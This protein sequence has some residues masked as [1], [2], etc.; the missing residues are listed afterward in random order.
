MN[1]GSKLNKIQKQ[2]QTVEQ[3]KR[4][5]QRVFVVTSEHPLV[6]DFLEELK[7]RKNQE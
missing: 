3:L 1:G 4:L 6:L 7:Y 5:K 2:D